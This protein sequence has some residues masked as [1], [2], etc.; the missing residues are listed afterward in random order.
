MIDVQ[1]I[2]TNCPVCNDVNYKHYCY[3][4]EFSYFVRNQLKSPD[5]PFELVK[6]LACGMVFVKNPLNSKCYKDD[7]IL[8]SL[9]PNTNITSR[10]YYMLGIIEWHIKKM[11]MQNP[12]IIEIG[13]G[14]GQLLSLA[15]QKGYTYQGIEPSEIRSRFIS[16]NYG[17]TP[18]N[19]TFSEFVDSVGEKLFDIIIFDNVVEHIPF[20]FEAIKYA[21]KLLREN[22]V[23]IVVTPN[24]HDIRNLTIPGFSKS[25]IVPAGHCNYFK[26][27]TLGR[28]I[29]R[30]DF[31]R[32]YPLFFA[33]E[34]PLFTRIGLFCKMV[35]EKMFRLYPVGL[36]FSAVKGSNSES[37]A[38]PESQI[39]SCQ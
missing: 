18:F 32:T 34:L 6:C 1:I 39:I 2:H 10:H 33:K 31:I 28:L 14:F 5:V 23:L 17:V 13:C 11:G 15:L 25:Q 38:K 7:D 4:G 3:S 37:K 20:P 22:G 26:H 36:Y 30:S 35:L 9:N 19:G 12:E 21:T 27:K 29:R 8:N 16:Q 24:H